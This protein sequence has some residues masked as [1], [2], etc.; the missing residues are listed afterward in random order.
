MDFI[1]KTVV[2]KSP[3]YP[4]FK[5][6]KNTAYMAPTSLTQL[7]MKNMTIIAMIKK[8]KHPLAP[9]ASGSIK[10]IIANITA[11]TNTVTIIPMIKPLSYDN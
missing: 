10:L 9:V 3:V 8:I 7:P 1:T 11:K 2:K 4:V 5:K 6:M